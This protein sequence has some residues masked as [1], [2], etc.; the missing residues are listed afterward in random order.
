MGATKY[1][2]DYA[3]PNT[4]ECMTYAQG[5]E[6]YRGF[7]GPLCFEKSPVPPAPAPKPFALQ[8]GKQCLAHDGLV[9]FAQA[10]DEDRK[11]VV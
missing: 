4:T 9:V 10:C 5:K 6:Y 7:I 11:S 8:H 1:Q 3:E 2:T